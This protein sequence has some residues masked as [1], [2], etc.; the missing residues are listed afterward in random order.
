MRVSKMQSIK[1]IQY[2]NED[3]SQLLDLYIPEEKEFSVFIYFHGGGLEAGDKTDYIIIAK[4]TPP[5]IRLRVCFQLFI[6]RVNFQCLV[7]KIPYLITCNTVEKTGARNMCKEADRKSV[8]GINK[9]IRTCG[10]IPAE[11]TDWA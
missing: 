7:H 11:L 8:A 6:R 3:K 5:Y 2:S 4:Q 1:N 9:V 10:A